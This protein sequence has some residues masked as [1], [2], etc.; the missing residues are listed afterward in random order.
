MVHDGAMRAGQ[1]REDLS[2]FLV[3][4]TRDS[5]A[6]YKV[7]GKTASEN[8]ESILD[9]GMIRAKGIHCL[10]GKEVKK[11]D[12]KIQSK[13]RVAC[14]TETPLDQIEHLIGIPGRTIN[15]DAYGFVFEKSFLVGK[16]AQ[17]AI[18]VNNYAA[19]NVH[20]AAFDRVFQMSVS[21]KF[22]GTMWPMLP[23]VNVMHGR[24]DFNWEREWRVIGSVDFE[25]SDLVCVILPEDEE[26]LRENMA[27]RGIAA[28][29][30]G[31]SYE[32]ML[33]E[34]AGQQRRTRAI[35]KDKYVQRAKGKPP[36]RLVKTG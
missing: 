1:D 11:L 23:L 17:P 32:Q 14:F 21:G 25:A 5:R 20:R 9:E 6:Q 28:I 18:Y 24:H 19:N 27:Y 30:P 2:R 22:T 13:F 4:L 8:F 16:G 35:W 12:Q 15:L 10:H 3:H 29:S 34:I 36:L 7:T 31:W 33:A 26:D